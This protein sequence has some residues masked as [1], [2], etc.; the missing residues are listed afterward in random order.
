MLE[1]RIDRITVK[2][3]R[4]LKEVSVEL[5]DL[6]V[7]VGPNGSGKSNFIDVLSLVRNGLTLGLFEAMH[8]SRAGQ[9]AELHFFYDPAEGYDALEN[10]EIEI[11]LVE[12][13][14]NDAELTIRALRKQNLANRLVH[15]QDGEEALEF[16]FGTGQFAGR[17]ID[18]LPKVI[19]LDIKMP[20]VDGI[21][22]LTAIK[23]NERTKSIPVVIVT[24]SAMDPDIKRCYE[25]GANS[26]IVKPVEFD[27][28]AKTI[29]ELGFYWMVV[30]KT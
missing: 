6:T 26:Y 3:F 4:S 10:I 12:D 29:S 18:K 2:N 5:D 25:L 23:A 13:N 24:S 19:L 28:F 14:P 7:L 9:A 30:N 22:V 17:D 8:R 21:S 15:L 1:N 11:L 20:R 27:D 16:L